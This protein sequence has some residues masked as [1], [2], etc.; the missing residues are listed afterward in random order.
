A[1]ESCSGLTSMTIPNS[2][3]SI[4]G[5]AFS[6]CSGLKS[7]E[8]PN[9][10][11]SIGDM[12]FHYCGLTSVTIGNSV[13]S[14]GKDAFSDCS[15]L[16]AIT[17]PNSVTSIGESAFRDCRGLIEVTINSN[18][19]LSKNYTPYDNLMYIFGGNVQKYIIGNSVTSIGEYA[20]YNCS[21]LTSIEIPN[22]V[23]SI[24]DMAFH[25]CGL[26]SVTI[27]NSVT[28]IGRGAFRYCRGLT[29]VTI[30]NSVV[31][32][33]RYAFEGC[34]GLTSVT[35]GNSVTS[36]ENEAFQSC[37]RLKSVTN[38]AMKPQQISSATFSN[39]GTLH[40]IKGFKNVY[41]SA[42]YWREFIIVDDI[43]PT[44]IEE[45]GLTPALSTREGVTYDLQGRHVEHMKQ[46]NVYIRNGRKFIAK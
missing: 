9:S 11:T 28:S 26:T 21:G 25:Y 3:T 35:I 24:G 46:G 1:F 8:I 17:I 41:A 34:S 19:I 2:V 29:S 22:S 38:L 27:G 44:G 14:I 23:T 15:G 4:G 39:Y 18:S 7:I 32:I 5:A 30:P 16:T 12:A 43:D 42:D 6:G 37:E 45:I 33:G 20:F 10:V 13:T 31:N 36:I 40:V